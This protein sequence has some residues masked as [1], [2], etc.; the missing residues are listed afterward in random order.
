MPDGSSVTGRPS[1][2]DEDRLTRDDVT[3]AVHYLRFT[4]TPEQVRAF[5]KGPVRVVVD[6]PNYQH[7]AELDAEQHAA[8]V[9]DL[10][11]LT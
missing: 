10:V 4:F 2:E 6:H 8:L 9:L 7:E 1:D 3:A 11:D 5:E